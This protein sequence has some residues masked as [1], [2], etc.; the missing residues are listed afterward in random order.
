[1]KR[2]LGKI[3]RFTLIS[4]VIICLLFVATTSHKTQAALTKTTALDGI[5]AWQALAAGTLA[6]GN[7]E[8]LTG[9]YATT[10]YIEIAYTAAALQSGV[11]VI[12]EIS[13]LTGDD[14]TELTTYQTT[15]ATP[16]LD[17]LDEDGG[18]SQGDPSINVTD[19]TGNYDDNGSLFFVIDTTVAESE[20]MRVKSEAGNAIT[21]C[22]DLKYDHV[23][24][25]VTTDE[26]YQNTIAIPFPAAY[27]RVIV[28]N[29]DADAGIHWRSHC[30]K[31]T[32]LD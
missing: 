29:T 12:I 19:S 7:S 18:A 5:D 20:V 24:E 30:S 17:D 15:A 32:S 2:R 9:S 16:N 31:V 1:M 13:M 23:S 6:V 26:V 10:V 25:E 3:M 21:L 28:N 8:S 4:L 22:Q 11:D 14:W 27:V